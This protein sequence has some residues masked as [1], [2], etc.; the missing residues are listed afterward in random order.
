MI[1]AEI[2]GGKTMYQSLVDLVES[3]L[4]S[5]EKAVQ[6]MQRILTEKKE[7][8]EWQQAIWDRQEKEALV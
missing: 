3:R 5:M 7:R 8:A 2:K 1:A 4:Q 6:S